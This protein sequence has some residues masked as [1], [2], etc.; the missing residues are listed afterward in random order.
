MF[1]PTCRSEFREGIRECPECNVPLREALPEESHEMDYVR[2]FE[3]TDTSLLPVIE[4]V[5]RAADIP[6]TVQGEEGL[7]V[8]PVGGFGA[9][10]RM[11][12]L[13]ASVYVLREHEAEARLLLD[14]LDS[15]GS[16]EE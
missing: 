14:K 3:T 2:V 10:E 7:N 4:S 13:G 15:P 16:T 11:H 8:L 1:C 12:G 9:A 6:F 5:L